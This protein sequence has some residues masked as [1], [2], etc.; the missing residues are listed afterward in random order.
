M[1]LTIEW[2]GHQAVAVVLTKAFPF[3]HLNTYG[4]QR[5]NKNSDFYQTAKV[6]N[7]TAAPVLPCTCTCTYQCAHVCIKYLY[8]YLH[9]YTAEYYLFIS[10]RLHDS[11][12]S[13]A[14]GKGL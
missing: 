2:S 12:A 9:L 6:V 1:V 4:G 13:A 10:F 8:Q 11:L 14:Y 3:L 7:V 5:L